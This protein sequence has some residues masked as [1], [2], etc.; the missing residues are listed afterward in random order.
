[1]A[2]VRDAEAESVEHLVA[3]GWKAVEVAQVVVE[4]FTNG[5]S[6]NGRAGELDSPRGTAGL[7]FAV[8]EWPDNLKG[9]PIKLGA[10]TQCGDEIRAEAV[11]QPP[12]P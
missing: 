3:D 12:L 11:N 9:N 4:V 6:G 7:V 2:Q 10:Y 1:M 8:A 5:A